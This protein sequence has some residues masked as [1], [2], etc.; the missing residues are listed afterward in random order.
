MLV[1]EPVPGFR[2]V[3][4]FFRYGCK[5]A[6]TDHSSGYFSPGYHLTLH[7]TR[8]V[9]DDFT[10]E[11][12]LDGPCG[13][14]EELLIQSDPDAV[15]SWFGRWYP[16]CLSLVPSRRRKTFLEGVYRA[17]ERVFGIEAD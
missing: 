14:L 3:P 11:Q 13:D 4:S 16:Q 7:V 6:A 5:D 2:G 12:W 17:A 8:L 9:P 1:S 15:L 10:L